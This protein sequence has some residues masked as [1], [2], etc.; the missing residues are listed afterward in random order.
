[1][2]SFPPGLQRLFAFGGALS[3]NAPCGK[4]GAIGVRMA[5]KPKP[6]DP[7]R[8]FDSSPEVIQLVVMLY[9]R[10]SA[11]LAEWRTVVG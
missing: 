4:D 10:H 5:R 3:T 1:M 2:G 11:A 9:V 6:D 8:W 7:F